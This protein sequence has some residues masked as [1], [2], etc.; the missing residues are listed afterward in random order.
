M[1]LKVA[2]GLALLQTLVGG[3]AWCGLQMCQW[4]GVK[5]HF[6]SC[7][8]KNKNTEVSAVVSEMSVGVLSG[9]G[10]SVDVCTVVG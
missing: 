7:G 3:W 10:R 6:F 2:L 8:G 9:F 4:R 1:S 5:L